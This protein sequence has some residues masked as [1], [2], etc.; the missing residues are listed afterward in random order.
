MNSHTQP[1]RVFR[2][3]LRYLIDPTFHP[4]DRVEELVAFCRASRI[5]QVMLFIAPEE[6]SAGH[7]TQSELS[8]YAEL[9]RRLRDR[10][11]DARIT[12]SLN[13]WS[14][15]YHNFR[16]RQLR[17]G[18]NFQRMVG[19]NGQVS[20]IAACPLCPN[21]QEW[22][23]E[24]FA[25]LV[26]EIQPVALWV[27]DDW[28]LH[29][30]GEELGW[31]GCFC[32]L[33][34]ERF[35]RIVGQNVSRAQIMG[36]VL[37]PG[38][39]HPWRKQ[40][41]N[42]SKDS[43]LEPAHRLSDAI[44]KAH[45]NTRI[46]LM[47]SPPD[48]HSL[49][50]RNWHTLQKII[51]REPAFLTRPNMPPY[52]E[53]PALRTTP[54]I[55]RLTLACLKRPIEVYPELENSPRC[56]PYSKSAAHTVW[57]C[58]HAAALG[59]HG[60]TIN[61]YDMMGNG[62]ALD[63]RF[64]DALAKA[65]DRLNA[66]T[67]LSLDDDDAEGVEVLFSPRV[68]ECFHTKSANS[69]A[70]MRNRS[71]I[72]SDVFFILG[73]AHGFATQ[74]EDEPATP[75][76]AC[77]QTLRAFDDEAIQRLL[78]RPALL[79]GPGVQVLVERGYGAQIGVRNAHW[80][81]Q[82]ETAFSYESVLED[83]AEVY[84]LSRPRMTAQRCA[85]RLLAMEP[86]H[87]DDVRSRICRADHEPVAPGLIVHRNERGGVM[88]MLAYPLDGQSQFF[89]GFFNVFRR[90]L[91][92]NV[93]LEAADGAP[94]ALAESHPLHLYRTAINNAAFL[95]AL[96]PLA[97]AATD[98]VVST[99]AGQLDWTSAMQLGGDGSWKPCRATHHQEAGV[100][101]V[102]IHTTIAPL[103]GCFLQVPY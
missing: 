2:Y 24:A 64:G 31:G 71:E 101:R 28:R 55:T 3:I 44:G 25:F 102:T 33:H 9:G 56:G 88:V 87:E 45:P 77:G 1:P 29:N 34:L 63:R 86:S 84:G 48:N 80:I 42:L 61:H 103:D 21:W 6:L 82:N 20:A 58:L 96:N 27:E 100:D 57:Q 54:A 47:S 52:T 18:Q 85:D 59:S 35:A 74:I 92:Q 15:V 16:G 43:L 13:P 69:I 53:E 76:A 39:P 94:L 68:A 11:A 72:W 12:L 83:D 46:G 95:A 65:K 70:D 62:I 75:I 78:A 5:E 97:D 36:K 22:L 50:G 38:E 4:D 26:R 37:A 67:T 79:D 8:R 49:E 19:E 32:K 30:H 73:I 60:I 17:A 66:I 23:C 10:L 91:L 98:P 7:P 89:M 90:R 40:W 51:G 41:L 14:T 93:L 99:P 81:T